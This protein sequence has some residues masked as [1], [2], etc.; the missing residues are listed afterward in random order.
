MDVLSFGESIYPTIIS[1]FHIVLKS[2]GEITQWGGMEKFAWGIFSSG[3]NL[4][5]SDFDY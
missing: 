3:A 5:R 1:V 4:T 2:K